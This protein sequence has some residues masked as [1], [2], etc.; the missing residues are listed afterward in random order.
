MSESTKLNKYIKFDIFDYTRQESFSLT[1]FG[2][3]G[4][5]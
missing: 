1:K 5:K 4:R 3:N 2:T